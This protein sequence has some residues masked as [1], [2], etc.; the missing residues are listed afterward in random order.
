MHLLHTTY[1]MHLNSLSCQFY[2]AKKPFRIIRYLQQNFWTRV[3]PPLAPPNKTALLAKYGFPYHLLLLEMH[4]CMYYRVDI[5]RSLHMALYKGWHMV[6]SNRPRHPVTPR[7]SIGTFSLQRNL[8]QEVAWILLETDC[9]R[10]C[11]NEVLNQPFIHDH[12]YG[13]YQCN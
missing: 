4:C 2:V 6:Q 12:H 5:W 3:W 1:L 7:K 13:W 11:W 10:S 9:K 8:L